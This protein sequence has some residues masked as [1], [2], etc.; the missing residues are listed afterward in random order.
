VVSY[1][2]QG[3]QRVSLTIVD[4]RGRQIAATVDGVIPA[5]QNYVF[6]QPG[7]GPIFA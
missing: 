7:T 3:A 1:A 5:G 4:Q 2:L 6:Q